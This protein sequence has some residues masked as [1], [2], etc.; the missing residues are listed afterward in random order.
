MGND[1]EPEALACANLVVGVY[2]YEPVVATCSVVVAIVTR[3]D[4]GIRHT[5]AVVAT[6][7]AVLGVCK[8]QVAIV[9]YMV[10]RAIGKRDHSINMV[11]R[12]LD[13]AIYKGLPVALGVVRDVVGAKRIVENAR[14]EAISIVKKVYAIGHLGVALVG[15]L[16][17]EDAKVV[18]Y[19]VGLELQLGGCAIIR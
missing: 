18:V 2:I 6:Q 14:L 3:L 4:V 5:E 13:T 16:V 19:A 9:G 12:H 1:V 7:R 17:R 8:R 10:Y 15:C 11:V